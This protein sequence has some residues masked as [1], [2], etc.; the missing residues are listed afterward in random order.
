M[1]SAV[2]TATT[3]ADDLALLSREPRPEKVAEVERL[4][5]ILR[6]SEAVYLTDFRG[7][8]VAKISE[9]RARFRAQETTFTIVKNNLLKRAAVSAGHTGWLDGLE[10]PVAIAVTN[11]DPIAPAKVIGKFRDDFK[12]A[13]TYLEFKAGLVQGV[14]IDDEGF[15]RLITLPGREELIGKLL[16]LL[17]YPMRGLLTVLTGLP[18][19][20]VYALEDLRTQRAAGAG[21]TGEAISGPEA[22]E[23]APAEPDAS[24]EGRSE[25]EAAEEGKAE[26]AA[27]QE[28]TAPEPEG[29]DTAVREPAVTETAAEADSAPGEPTPEASGSDEPK[30]PSPEA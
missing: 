7:L 9:L 3:H 6:E 13:G 28:G 23:A 15:K 17:T 20:L 2:E 24:E 30:S 22:A 29:G 8:D 14:V 26:P 25:P 21:S 27:A 11:H 16:Y 19:G 10:G 5:R 12:R 18:R 4:E 1:M